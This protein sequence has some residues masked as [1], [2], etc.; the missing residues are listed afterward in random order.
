MRNCWWGRCSYWFWSGLS[1]YFRLRNIHR[2]LFQKLNKRHRCRCS[3]WIYSKL[4]TM[5]TLPIRS[6]LL[7]CIHHILV[8]WRGICKCQQ[9]AEQN[10][11]KN[12]AAQIPL[13][14]KLWTQNCNWW[15]FMHKGPS[16][17]PNRLFFLTLFKQP[18]TPP[19]R[20]W[21]FMLQIFLKGYWKS[22]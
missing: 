10:T 16:P 7:V 2:A 21:T 22:A 14:T 15:T 13:A 3:T 1:G 6:W 18:L 17:V 9:I 5:F 12:N 19:P 4:H 8:T 11:L 20:F